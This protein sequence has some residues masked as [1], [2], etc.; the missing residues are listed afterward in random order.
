MFGQ[1]YKRAGWSFWPAALTPAATFALSHLYQSQDPAEIAGIL[2]I[3][4]LGSVVFSYIFI[5]WGGNIWAPF[6][7]HALLNLYWSVF[8]VDDTAL[9]GTYANAL[10]FAAIALAV[11]F[12]FVAPRLGWLVP[13]KNRN[14]G[15]PPARERGDRQPGELL[16]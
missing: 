6:A 1:L 8:A 10:R 5:Q 4:A 14:D 15:A 2:A 9:G 11:V 13:L 3:T 16:P 12:C 7:G